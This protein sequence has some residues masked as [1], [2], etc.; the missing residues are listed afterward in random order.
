MKSDRLL[1][2]APPVPRRVT[3]T[4]RE[5]GVADRIAVAGEGVVIAGCGDLSTGRFVAVVSTTEKHSP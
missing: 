1:R 4:G 2:I 5:P 3:V